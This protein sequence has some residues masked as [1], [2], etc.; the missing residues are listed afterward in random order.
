M[1]SSQSTESD[2]AS[3]SS[4]E[5]LCP[6]E[7]FWGDDPDPDR[8]TGHVECSGTD[9]AEHKARDLATR[10][11]APVCRTQL[12]DPPWNGGD[13]AELIAWLLEDNCIDGRG[14]VL[15]R[16]QKAVELTDPVLPLRRQAELGSLTIEYGATRCRRRYNPET[17][18]INWGETTGTAVPE[19]DYEIFKLCV[20]TYLAERDGSLLNAE[21]FL[22][23][24]DRVWHDPQFGSIDSLA[25]FI[26]HV[27]EEE[28]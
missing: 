7:N 15:H 22:K 8:E 11:V 24:A 6:R 26:R 25:Q 10:F 12:E 1:S 2:S 4:R 19:F 23:Y 14:E 20:H 16:E 9:P 21:P 5:P 3:L 28:S 18:Y 17:G 27:R 13:D